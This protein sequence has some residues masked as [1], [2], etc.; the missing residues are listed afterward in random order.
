[1]GDD[2]FAQSTFA[3]ASAGQAFAFFARLPPIG[4]MVSIIDRHAGGKIQLCR[5]FIL[6]S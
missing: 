1:M 6:K 3:G 5:Y 4:S 2:P